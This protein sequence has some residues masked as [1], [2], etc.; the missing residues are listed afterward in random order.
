MRTCGMAASV[1]DNLLTICRKNNVADNN[2]EPED[3]DDGEI[4]EL[5]SVNT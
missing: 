1:R 4:G 3:D 5:C 2:N